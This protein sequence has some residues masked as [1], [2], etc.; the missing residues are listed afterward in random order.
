MA[1]AVNAD[2]TV[3]TK[4]YLLINNKAITAFGTSGNNIV[5]LPLGSLEFNVDIT[6]PEG[7]QNNFPGDLYTI[8]W[9]DNSTSVYTLCEIKALGGK[10][11]HTYIRSSC[12]STSV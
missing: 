9:G 7:I 1:K 10:V 2:G 11:K 12:G 8:T 3:A 5:C 6:S 4:A